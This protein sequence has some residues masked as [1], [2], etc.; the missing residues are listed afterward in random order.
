MKTWNRTLFDWDA[1]TGVG[2]ETD[3]MVTD[4]HDVSVRLWH[5]IHG[6][7][8]MS[9][10]YHGRAAFEFDILR[11]AIGP[12]DQRAEIVQRLKGIC[13]QQRN[14][15][16]FEERYGTTLYGSFN[17]LRGETFCDA[18]LKVAGSIF[19]NFGV[20]QPRGYCLSCFKLSQ[21]TFVKRDGKWIDLATYLRTK[22]E[23]PVYTESVEAVVDRR[24]F[25]QGVKTAD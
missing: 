20:D 18:A 14:V 24:C 3:F 5:K 4:W 25:P 16:V 15:F 19:L 11:V 17:L 21:Q 1:F 13:N 10:P 9:L 22:N 2:V 23:I 12:T 7:R 6:L 8:I